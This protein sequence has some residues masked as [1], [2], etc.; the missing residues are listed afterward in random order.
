M[1]WKP[2][3]GFVPRGFCGA[4]G[5]ST[6]VQLVLVT[7][8]PGDPLAGETHEDRTVAE[9]MD[10]SLESLRCGITP[11]HNNIRLII[12]MCFPNL[13]FEKQMRHVWR[14]NAVLCSA[15]IESGPIPVAVADTC[16]RSYLLPQLALF[17]RAVV[18]ALGHKA[19]LRLARQGVSAFP[20]LHPSSRVS[21]EE[22][23]ASWR[24]LAARIHARS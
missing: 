2:H 3:A 1:Q 8:E 19:Q 21:N 22:K 16:V 18:G 9:L 7:A 24:A 5:T 14:T 23:H 17:P 11:F 10:F 12:E 4:L 15:A 20:A 6:E 13:P